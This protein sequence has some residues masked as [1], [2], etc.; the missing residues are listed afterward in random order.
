MAYDS[1]SDSP[2]L[3]RAH[4][5]QANVARAHAESHF[6]AVMHENQ[7]LHRK[8]VNLEHVFLSRAGSRLDGALLPAS[9]SRGCVALNSSI[10]YPFSVAL[11]AV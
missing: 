7:Q 2:S 5:T 6:R 11:H 10:R 3:L 1:I 4:C 8:I 9:A